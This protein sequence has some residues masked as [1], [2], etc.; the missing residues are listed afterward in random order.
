MA[1][2]RSSAIIAGRNLRC[3]P[4]QPNSRASRFEGRQTP[5]PQRRDDPGEDVAGTGAC[6]PRRRRRREAHPAIGR[7]DQGGGSFVD[8]DRARALRCFPRPLGLRPASSRNSWEFAFVRGDDRVLSFQPLGLAEMVIAS[9]SITLGASEVSASVSTCGK[10][11]IPGPTSR[12]PIRWSLTSRYRSAR[13]PRE[14][15]DRPRRGHPNV[16]GTRSCRGLG[17]K[18][19]RARHRPCERM[20]EPPVIFVSARIERRKL[21]RPISRHSSAAS[22][23]MSA[24]TTRPHLCMPDRAGAR[25]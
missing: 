20:D 12:Q 1:A 14:P 6:Q 13:S 18:R 2:T 22:M 16:A 19:D 3:S 4:M 21:R 10:S 8:D 17:R 5:R 15:V 25:A 23:P 9:A 24:R 7:C 11:P